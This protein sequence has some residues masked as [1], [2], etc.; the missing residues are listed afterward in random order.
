MIEILR[1]PKVYSFLHIPV[2]SGC[3]KVLTAMNREY[4][5]EEF[6]HVA[7]YLLVFFF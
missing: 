5:V 6:K 1:N 4:T 3:N 2:Q 7:D